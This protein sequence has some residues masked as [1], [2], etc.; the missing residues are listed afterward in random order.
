VWILDYI[1]EFFIEYAQ[2]IILGHEIRDIMVPSDKSIG[3]IFK[4]KVH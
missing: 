3:V 2:S 4:E 1:S